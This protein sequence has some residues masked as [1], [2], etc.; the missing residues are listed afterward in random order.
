MLSVKTNK[1]MKRGWVPRRW[2]A[3]LGAFLRVGNLSPLGMRALNRLNVEPLWSDIALLIV[4]FM[5][6]GMIYCLICPKQRE[7]I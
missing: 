4:L 5:L 1:Q 3:A 6:T 7:M 2:M